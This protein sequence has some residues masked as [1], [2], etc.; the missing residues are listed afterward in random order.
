M[1]ACTQGMFNKYKF[2]AFNFCA[3]KNFGVLLGGNT[4][5]RIIM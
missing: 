5:G 3:N 4:S 2:L 1:Y